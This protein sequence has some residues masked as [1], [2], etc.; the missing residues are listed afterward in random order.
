MPPTGVL[1]DKRSSTARM[2]ER[3]RSSVAGRSPKRKMP[4]REMSIVASFTIVPSGKTLILRSYGVALRELV[5]TERDREV[6]R[7]GEPRPHGRGRERMDAT[8]LLP[9]VE[10]RG[11]QLGARL[12]VSR[13]EIGAGPDEL[14]VERA[15]ELDVTVAVVVLPEGPDRKTGL[16]LLDRQFEPAVGCRPGV[17]RGTERPVRVVLVQQVALAG[18]ELAA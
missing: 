12:A 8:A 1:T 16:V 5:L 11:R 2:V 3:T 13:H 7:G 15:D 14:A 4:A 10:R 17:P 6:S 9:Q 18:D